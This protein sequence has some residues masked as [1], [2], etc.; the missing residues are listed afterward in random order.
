M[1]IKQIRYFLGVLEAKSFTKAADLLH[2]AQPAIGMQVRKLEEEL[3]V[4]LL[5]RHSRGVM[6]TGSG[7]ILARHGKMLLNDV[8]EL[9]R[10]VMNSAVEPAGRVTIG[11]SA[12]AMYTLAGPLFEACREKYPDISINLT[13]G[14]SAHLAELM[15]KDSLDAALTNDPPESGNLVVEPLAEGF[16]CLVS[17]NNS[18]RP[19]NELSEI[20]LQ[21][22]LMHDLIVSSRATRFRYRIESAAKEI[23]IMLESP[24]DVDSVP[25]IKE[26]VLRGIG[27]GLLSYCTV[28]AEVKDGRLVAR[29]I[30]DPE[31]KRT[32]S[33]V[34][35]RMGVSSKALMAVCNEIRT[36]V[37]RL[38][39]E[40]TSGWT[41]P[42]DEGN[43]ALSS[44]EAAEQEPAK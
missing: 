2:V 34:Y 31:V 10:L 36:I 30:I 8:K 44:R 6:P 15:T 26:L 37:G 27:S 9:R 20:P 38:I 18:A 25:A 11:M 29:R 35:S 13:E 1:D 4:Q 33:L 28:A 24:H 21:E 42:I 12:G 16:L 7:E 41:R 14:L 19:Q 39:A 40:K 17:R 22:A 43:N 5:V 23:D 3:G 32:V